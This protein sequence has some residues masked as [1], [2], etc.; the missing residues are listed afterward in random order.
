MTEVTH[1]SEQT[2]TYENNRPTT[3]DLVENKRKDVEGLANL[4]SIPNYIVVPIM[5]VIMI[6]A[7]ITSISKGSDFTVFISIF[8]ILTGIYAIA[9]T[10][11]FLK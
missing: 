9:R 3:E 4:V 2:P 11:I 1:E 7:I 6:F 10:I 8:G 5:T